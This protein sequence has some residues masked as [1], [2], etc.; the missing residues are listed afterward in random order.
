MLLL[1]ASLVWWG[2]GSKVNFWPGL[3]TKRVIYTCFC[4]FGDILLVLIQLIYDNCH[5]PGTA[6]ERGLTVW[7]KQTDATSDSDSHHKRS[8]YDLPLITPLIRKITVLRYFPFCPT[9]VGFFAKRK[10]E[11]LELTE[12]Q[13]NN[14]NHSDNGELHHRNKPHDAF[15]EV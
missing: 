15:S 8:T 10:R 9:F 5:I 3:V 14:P 11:N 12:I 2:H 13:H 6:E 1:F 7:N 4:L